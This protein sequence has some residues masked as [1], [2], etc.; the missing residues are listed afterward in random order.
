MVLGDLHIANSGTS[1]MKTRCATNGHRIDV[2]QPPS[3]KV[4]PKVRPPEPMLM[5]PTLRAGPLP[6]EWI[7][8]F[9]SWFTTFPYPIATYLLRIVY[10][11]WL[12]TH[13]S[14]LRHGVS[15]CSWTQLHADY[16][17]CFIYFQL[18]GVL[19][20]GSPAMST[21]WLRVRIARHALQK[22]K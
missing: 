21:S 7:L 6:N 1:R 5:H 10:E 9:V 22:L 2:L 4:P 18:F 12:W 11:H 13:W 16:C 20:V 14:I 8:L 3:E 19:P 17:T 15:V